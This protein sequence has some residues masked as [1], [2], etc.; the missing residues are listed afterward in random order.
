MWTAVS[1]EVRHSLQPFSTRV[2]LTLHVLSLPVTQ[3]LL[4]IK[5]LGDGA[6]SPPSAFP[7]SASPLLRMHP[8]LP[9]ARLPPGLSPF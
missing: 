8:Q 6:G 2:A 7:T 4:P 5:A 9:A 3:A 1:W